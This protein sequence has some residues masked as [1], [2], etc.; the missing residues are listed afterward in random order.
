MICQQTASM[1]HIKRHIDSIL[2]HGL[3]AGGCSKDHRSSSRNH[4]HFTPYAIN[5][6]KVISGMRSDCE[7]VISIDLKAAIHRG[8]PFYV[9]TNKVI[10]SP[11]IGGVIPPE[12][13]HSIKDAHTGMPIPHGGAGTG[14]SPQYSTAITPG[15][16]NQQLAHKYHSV[17]LSNLEM[18]AAPDESGQRWKKATQYA[19]REE[20]GKLSRRR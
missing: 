3:I 7:A 20:R 6:A 15:A 17:G 16:L 1:E 10:L 5:N 12:F 2:K 8:I 11:G 4:V 9:S 19:A 13:I 18:S 14:A